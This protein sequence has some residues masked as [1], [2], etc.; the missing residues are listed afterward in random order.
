ARLVPIKAHELFLEAA[1]EVRRARPDARFLVI[2]DGERR[3]E[4][5]ALAAR[6]GVAERTH[7][8]GFRSDLAR[9][10]ADLDVV[11]LCSRNEGLPVTLIEALAS[12]RPVAS[13][14]VGAVRDLVDPGRTGLLVPSGDAAALAGGI[15]QILA[16]PAEAARMGQAGRAH[17]S[18][19]FSID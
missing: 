3:R 6:L 19:R 4:L 8:L 11:A 15:L 13:T 14:E 2:G 18:P 12:A 9:L 16:D 17:V 10:Y 5:E 1:R 7:F